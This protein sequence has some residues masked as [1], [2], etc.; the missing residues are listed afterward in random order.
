VAFASPSFETA[1]C[2]HGKPL[3]SLTADE[4]PEP[5][6]LSTVGSAGVGATEEAPGKADPV[7]SASSTFCISASVFAL[8]IAA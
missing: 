2:F 1:G 8:E 7:F 4:L 6:P 3:L 5:E